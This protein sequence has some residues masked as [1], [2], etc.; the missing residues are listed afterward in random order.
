MVGIPCIYATP[1]IIGRR[2]TVA[3]YVSK[4]YTKVIWRKTYKDGISLVQG[5]PLWPKT[6]R[7]PVLP[8]PWTKGNVGRPSNYVRRKGRN[9]T[10]S[11]SNKNKM[12][13]QK[14]I[15]TCSNC[16]QQGQTSKAAK[17]PLF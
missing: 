17:M 11:S 3:D 5:M 8:P 6:N 2:E 9:E 14:R 16:L 10:S 1:V 7:L 13:L 4:F 15:M 12:P